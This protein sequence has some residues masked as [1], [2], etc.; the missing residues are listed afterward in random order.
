MPTPNSSVLWSVGQTL[1]DAQKLQARQNIDATKVTKS[2]TTNPPTTTVVQTMNVMTDGRVQADGNEIGLMAP[3]V[4]QNDG[5][6]VLVAK[7][8]GSPGI[9][10]ASWEPGANY[11]NNV[12]IAIYNTTTYEQIGAAIEAGF[13]VFLKVSN[14][15]FVPMSRYVANSSAIFTS[16]GM[17]GNML[18]AGVQHY[19]VS[20]GGWFT[21]PN[22]YNGN[23]QIHLPSCMTAN[24]VTTL[25]DTAEE[26]L[27][28]G[29]LKIGGLGT[30]GGGIDIM[31]KHATDGS[32]PLQVHTLFRTNATSGGEDNSS[33]FGEITATADS[34][35][36][37]FAIGQYSGTN[38]VQCQLDADL[39]DT[40]TNIPSHYRITIYK[41]FDGTHTRL[42]I[43]ARESWG[44]SD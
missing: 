31:M 14:T 44:D 1:T 34:W 4:G 17:E 7:W 8:T 19:I 25:R 29:Q 9:G 43:S 10:T 21:T 2:S 39:W 13:A 40:N 36:R 24:V 38:N 32:L 20:A 26:W 22:Y 11:L 42:L 15:R 27:T 41:Y 5:G 16:I 23:D 28:I 33:T 30:Q 6:K 37:L 12:F 35:T 3:S 18:T